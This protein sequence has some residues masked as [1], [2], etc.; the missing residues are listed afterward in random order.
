MSSALSNNHLDI[1]E[2]LTA[3]LKNMALISFL[4]LVIAAL[5]VHLS[6]SEYRVQMFQWH[7]LARGIVFLHVLFTGFYVM[8]A[9]QS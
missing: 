8:K 6:S 7:Y 2:M 3:K 1:L 4:Y 5:M 9:F